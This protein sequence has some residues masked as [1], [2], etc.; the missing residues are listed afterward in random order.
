MPT[1]SI[2]I[3]GSMNFDLVFRAARR[4]LRGET[5]PGHSFNTFLGGKGFNQAVAAAR[6]GAQVTLVGRVGDDDFGRRFLE[7]LA[8]EGI[9]TQYVVR[10]P[11]NGTGVACPIVT[12]DGGNAII[13][14]PRA[15][16]ALAPADVEAATVVLQAADALLLQLEVPVAASQRAAE[17]VRAA[18]GRI[19]LNPA[20][21]RDLPGDFLALVDLLAPNEI[22]AAM[23]SGQDAEALDLA[24]AAGRFAARGVKNTIV[25]LGSNGAA[26]ATAQSVRLVPPFRVTPI[27]TTA[28]GD[29]FCGALAVAWAEGQSLAAAARWANAAGALA[30]TVLGAEPSLPGRPAVEALIAA[31]PAAKPVEA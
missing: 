20:P 14:V 8:A 24:L 28:A 10:D 19:V 26:L 22:E 5:L 27:D 29:A 25:T 9:D 15:N 13:I 16:M 12:D 18:G 6:L 23:L 4:P 21:A 1:P 30:A 11:A 7:K 3:V 17:I 31:Q 2:V